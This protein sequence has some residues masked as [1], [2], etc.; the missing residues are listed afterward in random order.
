MKFYF[1]DFSAFIQMGNHGPYV[2]ACYALMFLV[3]LLLGFYPNYK[4]NQLKK[5]ARINEY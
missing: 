1:D 3:L 2:W 4:I 5:L